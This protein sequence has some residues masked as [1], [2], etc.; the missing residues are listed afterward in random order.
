M[1]RILLVLPLALLGFT[2]DDL[3]RRVNDLVP[4]LGN[5]DVETRQKATAGLRA[6]GRPSLPILRDLFKSETDPEIKARIEE[7]IHG[8]EAIDWRVGYA[9]AEKLAADKK[10]PLLIFS[11]GGPLNTDS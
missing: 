8:Y 1:H 2:Q 9:D 5:D 3:A 10:L 11:I 7:L 4:R 6:L